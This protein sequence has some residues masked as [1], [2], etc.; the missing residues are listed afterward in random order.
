MPP[1]EAEL[2]RE[3]GL[4]RTEG[5]G[6]RCRAADAPRPERA[7]PARRRRSGRAAQRHP[8]RGGGLDR[9]PPGAGPDAREGAEQVEAFLRAKA[10]DRARRARRETRAAHAQGRAPRLGRW[11]TR[12][13]D[14]HGPAGL[15]RRHRAR[16]GRPGRAASLQVPMLGGSVPMYLFTDSLKAPVIGVPIVNH[17]NNQ[18]GPT[19]TCACRTSGTGSRSSRRSSP[20]STPTGGDRRRWARQ[21]GSA[22]STEGG[23]RGS[24]PLPPGVAGPHPHPRYRAACRPRRRSRLAAE[25]RAGMAPFSSRQPRAGARPGGGGHLGDFRSS[26]LAGRAAGRAG[27]VP[28][29]VAGSP[30]GER[31]D[32]TGVRSRVEPGRRWMR[33]SDR[34]LRTLDGRAPWTAAALVALAAGAWAAPVSAAQDPAIAASRE[35]PPFPT[36]GVQ[37]ATP[38]PRCTVAG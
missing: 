12:R 35:A 34:L 1:V 30:G 3:L 9:L 22:S 17:D 14:R 36:E 7:R 24:R 26:A 38:A 6:A 4:G 13:A 21:R 23:R 29:P 28:Q 32:A 25:P 16:R 37:A 11:A 19:R 8:D 15:A 5:S 20:A 10:S 31:N 2:R 18:H 33:I 27:C